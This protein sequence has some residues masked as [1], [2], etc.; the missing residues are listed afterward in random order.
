MP[1]PGVGPGPGAL[2]GGPALSPPFVPLAPIPPPPGAAGTVLPVGEAATQSRAPIHLRADAPAEALDPSKLPPP[3]PARA[4]KAAVGRS[5]AKRDALLFGLVILLVVG[6][7]AGAYFYFTRSASTPEPTVAGPAP[8]PP[9]G[10]AKQPAPEAG[11]K[12]PSPAPAAGNASPAEPQGKPPENPP[13][14]PPSIPPS[15]AGTTPPPAVAPAAPV[16]GVATTPAP[17]T[18]APAGTGTQ[19]ALPVAAPQ[20]SPRFV[21]Y[22]ESIRVSGVF[23]GSPARALIDGRLVRQGELVEPM[24]GIKFADI[25]VEA[26]QI[27][28]EDAAGARVRVKYL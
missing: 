25:D 23:Q 4:A 16:P 24:L 15:T 21:R 7:G 3:L 11:G 22:A 6:G 17:A 12:A 28:L 2:I 8:T 18:P 19:A 5:Q 26:K 13:A 1:L 14:F 27:I 10:G 9:A 20:A